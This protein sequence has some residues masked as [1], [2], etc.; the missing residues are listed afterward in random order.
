MAEEGWT[1]E[2]AMNEMRSFGLTHTHD[3]ICPSLAKYEREFPDRSKNSP[4]LTK[5]RTRPPPS[6]ARHSDNSDNKKGR[7]LT[8]ALSRNAPT[9]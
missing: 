9:Q 2:E 1:A 7:T 4:T 8:S 5:G 3:F 6:S